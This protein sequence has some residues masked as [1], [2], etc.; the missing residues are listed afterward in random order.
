M[1]RIWVREFWGRRE[2]CII[3]CK[4]AGKKQ[5]MRRVHDDIT[6]LLGYMVG[7]NEHED[8]APFEGHIE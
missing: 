4:V 1:M 6:Y 7:K 2:R 8:H 3:M 5:D